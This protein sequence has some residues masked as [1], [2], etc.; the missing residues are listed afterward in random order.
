MHMYG[1]NCQVKAKIQILMESNLM[2]WNAMN[3]HVTFVTTFCVEAFIWSI[4]IL[5]EVKWCGL[6]TQTTHCEWSAA[7]AFFSSFFL[8]I[9]L[10]IQGKC[11]QREIPH[12]YARN[13]VILVSPLSYTVHITCAASLLHGHI[14]CR[15]LTTA[16]L[17]THDTRI[18]FQSRT[19][20]IRM[21]A[22]FAMFRAGEV[23]VVW[24]S[25]IL[26]LGRRL[27][28]LSAISLSLNIPPC[29]KFLQ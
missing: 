12:V 15:V 10:C 20:Y 5:N 17:S 18:F 24:A 14:N 21:Y 7:Q 23:G 1:W 28:C 19:P 16:Y 6:L 2:K 25:V 27:F 11:S 13:S 22:F 8:M 3:V 4:L 26:D 29:S 9:L